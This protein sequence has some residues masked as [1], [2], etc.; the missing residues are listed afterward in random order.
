MMTLVHCSLLEDVAFEVTEVRCCLGG[1]C[2]VAARAE[3][4]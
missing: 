2:I 4:L 3:M 1:G